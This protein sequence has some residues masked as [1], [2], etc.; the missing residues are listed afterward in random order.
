MWYVTEVQH[1]TE[2]L[3]DLHRCGTYQGRTTIVTQFVNLVDNSIVLFAGCTIYTVI[4]VITNHWTVGRNLYDIEF[5]DIPE[6]TSLCC[7][8]TC[9]TCQ[10]MI[11]TE[12]V[13]QGDGGERL[14]GVFHFHVLLSFYSL[15]QSVAPLTTFHDTTGLLVDNLHFTVDYHILIVFIKHG[16]CL[17]QL[18][19]GMYTLT[20]HTV[21]REQLVFLVY[22]LFLSEVLILQ[23]RH[24]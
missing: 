9:H 21:V 10:F 1:P 14:C 16:I 5:I 19:Q 11:H 4:L 8:G 18:L 20:L 15:M 2:Q 13:L 6:L 7:S 3:R 24:L 17:Q 22:A 12:V 23:L